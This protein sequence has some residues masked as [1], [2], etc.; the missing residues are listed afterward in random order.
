ML[1]AMIRQAFTSLADVPEGS[2]YWE[3]NF[4]AVD[5]DLQSLAESLVDALRDRRNQAIG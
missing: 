3:R 4:G 2:L 1:L 5:V